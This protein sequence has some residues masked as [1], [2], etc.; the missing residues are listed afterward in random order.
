M[1][2]QFSG[3]SMVQWC[4]ERSSTCVTQRYLKLNVHLVCG[5]IHIHIF[6]IIHVHHVTCT[7]GLLSHVALCIQTEDG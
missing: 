1:R 7:L 3:I 5:Y 2:T 4:M 6:I